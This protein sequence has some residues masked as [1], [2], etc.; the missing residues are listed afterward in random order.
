MLDIVRNLISSIFGKILLAIMVLSFAL[1]GVGDILTSGNSQLAAKVGNEKITLDEFYYKFQN[2]IRNYNQV[3]STNIS[4][5]EAYDGNLHNALLNELV[6][7]KMIKNYAKNNNILINEETL[8]AIIITMPQFKNNDD[9]FSETKYKSYIINNFENEDVF[10]TELENTIY[11][12]IIYEIFDISNFLDESIIKHLYSYEGE[13]RLVSFFKLESDLIDV[14]LDNLENFFE[15]NKSRYE[16]KEEVIVD[17]IKIDIM[18]FVDTQ[19]IDKDVSLEY[20]NK[21]IDQYKKKETRDIEFARFRD[22]ES[23]QSFSNNYKKLGID[24][25]NDYLLTNKIEITKLPNFDGDFFPDSI[26]KKIFEL[27]MNEVSQP[28][29]LDELGYYVFKINNI[30]ESK[31]ISFEDA[32][33]EI[34]NNLALE[35]AYEEYDDAINLT[36]EMLINDYNILEIS[37]V[38]QNKASFNSTSFANFQKLAGDNISHDLKSSPVGFISDV[39]INNDENSAYVFTIKDKKPPF[40]PSLDTVR[41][42]V[43][44]DYTNETK[45][46]ELISFADKLLVELQF[47]NVDEFLSYA[48]KYNYILEDEKS[49]GRENQ[50]LTKDTV[51]NIYN[52]NEG[53][54][55]K[56]QFNNGEIG[57]GI[58]KKIIP[59]DSLISDNFYNTVKSNVIDNYN[60]SLETIIS[61]II[62]NDTNFEIYNQN[63]DKL[64]M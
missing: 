45:K 50:L 21:N 42:K 54:V 51:E 28:I 35:F 49:I 47:K 31:L 17:Y 25:L 41:E 4:L 23:A 26:S 37:E 57:L 44:E 19:N 63:I 30:F 58:L 11:Q 3:N 6:Y 12:G 1:W 36:D 62:I 9:I 16:T 24:A 56:I 46:K 64:F 55:F 5:R 43:I 48:K 34:I 7:L 20:Y 60:N 59:P 40:I 61:N 32:K 13:K 29:E 2:F 8:K 53:N 15:I 10:L 18:N 14:N 33:D 39:F 22:L 52:I 38:L 27:S